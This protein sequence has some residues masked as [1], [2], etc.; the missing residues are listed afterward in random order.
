MLFSS[1]ILLL[2]AEKEGVEILETLEVEGEVGFMASVAANLASSSA[3][4]FPGMSVS[5]GRDPS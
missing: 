1:L 2:Q 4:S 5:E 3:T